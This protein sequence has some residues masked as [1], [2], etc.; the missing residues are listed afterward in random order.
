[1]V[2]PINKLI[3]F[4]RNH[5]WLLIVSRDWH[6][7]SVLA[8][9]NKKSHCIRNTEGAKFHPDLLINQDVTVISKGEFDLG[10]NSYSAFNGDNL[11][12]NKFL[13]DNN[14]DTVYLAGLATDYCV[15]NTAVD[16][17]KNGFITYVVWDASKGV[18]SKK[19]EPETKKEFIKNQIK[20]IT[21]KSIFTSSLL[22]QSP[23]V[24]GPSPKP[25]RLFWSKTL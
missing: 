18:Y 4:A 24:P 20:I 16:S 23:K 1:M 11:S 25:K 22:S 10:R 13:T 9:E 3:K 19:S 14:V 2:G 8:I 12:L 15:K 6:S 17:V 21:T 7:E 5:H